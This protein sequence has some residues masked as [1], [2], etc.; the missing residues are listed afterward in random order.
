MS[1]GANLPHGCVILG[2]PAPGEADNFQVILA[3]N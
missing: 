1:S 3:I 2:Q